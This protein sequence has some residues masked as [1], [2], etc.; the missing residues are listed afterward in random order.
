MCIYMLKQIE[1]ENKIYVNIQVIYK[2]G[3]LV[4]QIT[5]IFWISSDQIYTHYLPF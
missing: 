2:K 5:K 3:R 1:Q 4:L